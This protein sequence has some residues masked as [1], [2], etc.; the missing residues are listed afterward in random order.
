VDLIAFCRCREQP[1]LPGASRGAAGTGLG[2][3]LAVVQQVAE[4]LGG[5][6]EFSDADSRWRVCL[7]L[8]LARSGSC[9]RE[10]SAKR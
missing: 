10:R 8:P 1:A 4:R 3:G 2:L 6:E 5:S 7:R 9:I